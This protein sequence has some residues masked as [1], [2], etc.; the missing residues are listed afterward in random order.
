MFSR[1]LCY[2]SRPKLTKGFSMNFINCELNLTSRDWMRILML[3]GEDSSEGKKII[4]ILKKMKE[5]SC[6]KDAVNAG[7]NS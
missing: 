4:T 3:L 7:P 6:L 5:S 2:I 1:S